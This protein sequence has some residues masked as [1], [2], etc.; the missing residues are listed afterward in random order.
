MVNVQVWTDR[1]YCK[2]FIENKDSKIGSEKFQSIFLDQAVGIAMSYLTEKHATPLLGCIVEEELPSKLLVKSSSNHQQSLIDMLVNILTSVR[3]T[4]GEDELKMT[5]A[6]VQMVLASGV[7]LERHKLEVSAK[8]HQPVL[9]AESVLWFHGCMI[10]PKLDKANQAIE[11]A[12]WKFKQPQRLLTPYMALILEHHERANE[13]K[14]LK[15]FSGLLDE[16]KQELNADAVFQGLTTVSER[17]THVVSRKGVGHII[18]ELA[19]CLKQFDPLL[20][21]RIQN[22]EVHQKAAEA[23]VVQYLAF[24]NVVKFLAASKKKNEQLDPAHEQTPV[25]RQSTWT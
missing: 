13:K 12:D 25:G 7:A 14:E 24:P 6:Y 8:A 19:A 9:L 15:T 16:M 10:L 18:R 3:L 23:Y 21:S 17:C 4:W 1:K 5:H 2:D 11:N 20:E 22:K